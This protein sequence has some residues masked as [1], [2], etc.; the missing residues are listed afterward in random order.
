MF[1]CLGNEN[2]GPALRKCRNPDLVP[3]CRNVLKIWAVT[4]YYCP[5]TEYDGKV[6]FSVCLFTGGGHPKGYPP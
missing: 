2:S 6:M 4:N 1:A 3:N 5:H